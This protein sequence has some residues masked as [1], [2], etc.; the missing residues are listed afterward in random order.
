MILQQFYL[1][2]LSQA[3]YLIADERSRR[4]VV[5]DP[6]RDVEDYLVFAGE[7]GLRIELVVLTHVHA[8]FVPGHTELA[9]RTGAAV[10]MSELAPVD[11]EVR[12]LLDGEVVT[13]GAASTGVSIE[14]M[15]TP[16]HTPE[17]ITLAVREHA[18]DE[19]PAALLTGDTLFLG[20]VGRPDLLGAAGRRPEEM[21]RDLYRSLR[22]RIL[23]LPDRVKIYPGHGAGS[24]CG[25]ALSSATVSTLGEQRAD[26][27]ALADM[28]EDEFVTAVTEGLG[29]PPAYFEQDV[30]VN[31][32]GHESFD[33][34][35]DVPELSATEAVE[36]GRAGTLLLD[37]RDDQAF[38]AGHL[39]GAVN[40]GLSG[41][42]AEYAAAVWAPEQ[43]VVLVGSA[44]DVTEARLR[45]ARVGI[46]AVIGKFTAL[47][48]LSSQPDLMRTQSRL[49]PREA[50]AAL[51]DV[52]GLQVVDVRSP[53]EFACGALPGAVNMPLSRL[54]TSMAELDPARPVLLNCAGGYRS[55]A[56]ASLLLS[57]GFSDVSDLLGG[58]N[59]WRFAAAFA[60]GRTGDAHLNP[61]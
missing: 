26:N 9:E 6:R 56:A 16:G 32:T 35:A 10:A 2:C 12:H 41:R 33:P 52:L 34:A 7:R 18:S 55:I 17:S 28:T 43:P 57:G 44:A 25:K 22:R 58:W 54:R 61:T 4:A 1:S 49:T 21:A 23:P 45:L 42:F 29:E 20:D 37:V 60:T 27:Y 48:A 46:D 51:R 47:H 40:V 11:F 39:V 30:A 38:T 59:R 31:R 53:G 13:L 15:A 5:V 36:A 50:A 8:D 24:A 14:V 19:A 3:S